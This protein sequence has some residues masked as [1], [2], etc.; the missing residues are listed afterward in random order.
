MQEILATGNTLAAKIREML[1]R[2]L[3]SPE[4]EAKRFSFNRRL[5]RLITIGQTTGVKNSLKI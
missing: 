3:S 5:E 1:E 4:D 2:Q